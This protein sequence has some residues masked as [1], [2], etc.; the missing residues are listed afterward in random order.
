MAMV[1]AAADNAPEPETAA[2]VLAAE[3]SVV[4]VGASAGGLAVARGQLVK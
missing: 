4:D 1:H 2:L 3:C